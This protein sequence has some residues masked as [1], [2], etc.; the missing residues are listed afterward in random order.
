M[1][2]RQ[3]KQRI[4]NFI[5]NNLEILLIF[6]KNAYFLRGE[7]ML[8]KKFIEFLFEGAH[9]Q[10]WNDISALTALRNWTNRRIK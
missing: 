4:L 3:K 10:R 8:S 5:K 7:K 9:I 6:M 2:E 1:Q